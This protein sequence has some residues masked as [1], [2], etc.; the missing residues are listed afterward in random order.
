MAL[1]SNDPIVAT[2]IAEI[3]KMTVE[4]IPC[5]ATFSDASVNTVMKNVEAANAM[6]NVIVSTTNDICIIIYLVKHTSAN[7]AISGNS[8]RSRDTP[9][10]ALKAITSLGS[11]WLLMM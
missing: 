7:S 4:G 5:D 2:T 10:P 6:I 9:R 3:M 11:N 8:R 1:A